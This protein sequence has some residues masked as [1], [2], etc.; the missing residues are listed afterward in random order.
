MNIYMDGGKHE[1]TPLPLKARNAAD[2]KPTEGHWGVVPGH[3]S[4]GGDA[5]CRGRPGGRRRASLR[6]SAQR[7]TATVRRS[8]GQ[9]MSTNKS[10]IFESSKL[11]GV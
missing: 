4:G 7:A 1:G 10:L 5:N 3:D 6:G 8:G 9:Q 11:R 2:P